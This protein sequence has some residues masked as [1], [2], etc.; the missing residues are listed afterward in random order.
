MKEDSGRG[1]RH[2]VPSPLPQHIVDFD[3]VQILVER[4]AVV[5]AGGGVPVV[6]QPNGQSRGV[7]AV[8]DKDRTTAKMANLLDIPD[9]I[10]LT[11]VPRVAVHF[12]KPEQRFLDRV[13]LSEIKR[14]HEGGISRRAAW[15][16]RSTRPCSSSRAAAGAASSRA[17]RTRSRRCAARPARRSSPTRLSRRQ[18]EAFPGLPC[19]RIW[20][21]IP[22][23][24]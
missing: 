13:S 18:P 2:V 8:I 3:L 9:I 20:Q 19:F 11:A 23:G 24:A 6:R 21:V 14:L 22:G 5:I 1:Y 10:I 16:R 4:G 12:G 17:S 15:G 7:E